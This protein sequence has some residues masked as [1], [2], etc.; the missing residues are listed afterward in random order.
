[1]E[2]FGLEH[3]KLWR[4]KSTK[5]C[6]FL[7]F[8]YCVVFGSVLTYQWFTFG[9]RKNDAGA[10][11][12][13]GYQNIRSCQAYSRKYGELTDETLQQ[14]VKDYQALHAAGEEK[15]MQQTD[16]AVVNGSWIGTLYPE[17]EEDEMTG[18]MIASC[19]LDPD[20]LTGFYERRESAVEKFLEIIGQ[21]GAEGEYL[22]QMNE[23]VESPFLW[24]WT[25]GWSAVLGSMAA[26]LGIV[27]ALFLAIV[28]SSLFAGEWH[29]HMSPLLLSTKNGW[30]KIAYAKVLAGLA[31]T[32]EL[33]VLLAS[34]MIASQLFFLGTE[35][36]DMPIQNIK[37]IAVA[38]MNMLQ[39]EIYEYAFTLLGAVGFAGIVMMISACCK[40]QVAALL[41]S[42]AVVY[43][44]GMI[45]QYFPYWLE[46]AVDLLP[47]VGS[48]TDVF[49]TNTFYLFG[50]YLWSP[51]LLITV[52]VLI[53][54]LCLPFAV[55]G[56]AG[57]MRT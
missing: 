40:H 15:S 35:G 48:G 13:D 53:G 45:K 17:L 30:E 10:K 1:M 20:K 27:M 3:R 37:M 49:R 34:G 25:A 46:K 6:V 44:P 18:V 28:L 55:K 24:K 26:D 43:G 42:L 36:W 57:R 2:L 51:Y 32:L 9:S 31:F 29:D 23:K 19:Y 22:L 16:W 14:W 7:C 39:A 4:R 8:L 33:F 41:L 11:N 12:F 54:M 21:T 56:W 52:P 38:P 5:I 47:L 50:R